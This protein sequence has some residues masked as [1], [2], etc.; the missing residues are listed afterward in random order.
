MQDSA[1]ANIAKYVKQPKKN[2]C[3]HCY[4]VFSTE[5]RMMCHMR[6][7]HELEDYKVYKVEVAASTKEQVNTNTEV[8]ICPYCADGFSSN[9]R[10]KCH[11]SLV[12]E[13]QPMKKETKKYVC[14][15]CEK[16]FNIRV[17]LFNHLK[18]VHNI[19]KSDYCS[20]EQFDCAVCVKSFTSEKK[21]KYHN[22][23]LHDKEQILKCDLCE[24]SFSNM[25]NLKSHKS[26]HIKNHICDVCGSGWSHKGKLRLHHLYVHASDEERNK[27]TTYI[28][29][30]CPLRFYT[31]KR[32]DEHELVHSV[33]K[34]YQCN[35]CE[36]RVKTPT[37]LR[38][39]I[40]GGHMGRKISQEQRAIYN[41]RLRKKKQEKK[42]E[43]GGLYR[44]G[45]DRVKYNEYMK[46]FA[47]RERFQCLYCEKK[48]TNL[49]FHTKMHH[50]EINP[51]MFMSRL[52]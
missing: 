36:F 50:K 15:T 1:D 18:Y 27:A 14:P 4:V 40:N 11:M 45:D 31:Q 28:C 43:N 7:E 32:L 44:T 46:N 24:K 23:L 51:P 47:H 48:T 37:G 17:F 34:N 25:K 33:T 30:N 6:L 13:L 21:L 38:M 20:I 5:K 8:T 9:K 39:H 29:T 19:D 3:P 52:H 16:S 49:D 26:R 22:K 12:H 41:E 42:K 2:T 10:M 35:Q